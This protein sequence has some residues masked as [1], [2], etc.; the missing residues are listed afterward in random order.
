MPSPYPIMTA[1]KE[2]LTL[3]DDA[4]LVYSKYLAGEFTADGVADCILVVVNVDPHSV[5]ETRVHLDLAALGLPE[6]ASFEVVDQ[7]TEQRFTWGE[8]NYVRL[9]A[10]NQPAHILSVQY[11][12][13]D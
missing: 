3:S 5:R 11:R 10:F 13:A 4:I 7:L 2:P 12:K 6:D 8:H 9:D 1:A